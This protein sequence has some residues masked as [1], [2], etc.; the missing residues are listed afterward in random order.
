MGDPACYLCNSTARGSWL[1]LP[2]KMSK[3]AKI[4]GT[5]EGR[6]PDRFAR[7]FVDLCAAQASTPTE[8]PRT[9][10]HRFECGHREIG[11]SYSAGASSSPFAGIDLATEGP[12]RMCATDSEEP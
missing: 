3:I 1:C 2:H 5:I 4:E 7:A 10:V 6:D 12:C 8:P 9:M 11:G